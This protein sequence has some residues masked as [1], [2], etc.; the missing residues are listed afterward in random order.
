MFGIMT[1]PKKHTNMACLLSAQRH[2]SSSLFRS[3]ADNM[4]ILF[5]K[6]SGPFSHFCGPFNMIDTHNPNNISQN[7]VRTTNASL[8]HAN[9][10]TSPDSFQ[11]QKRKILLHSLE[12]P[13]QGGK[14]RER[15]REREGEKK[16]KT[17]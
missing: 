13:D 14:E 7:K 2:T 9:W 4:F 16:E 5:H 11:R 6:H 15:E 17:I 1:H 12:N 8:C 3:I 10:K